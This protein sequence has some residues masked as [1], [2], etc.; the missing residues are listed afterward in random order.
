MNNLIK[1]LET[2]SDL[3]GHHKNI[4]AKKLE[5]VNFELEQLKASLNTEEEELSTLYQ[6]IR[7]TRENSGQISSEQYILESELITEMQKSI[8]NI[9]ERIEAIKLERSNLKTEVLAEMNK[10]KLYSNLATDKKNNIRQNVE[11]REDN[12]LQEQW[13]ANR[14]NND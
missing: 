4:A 8:K 10:E 1:S 12:Q 3:K 2:L 6:K 11:K 5:A 7:E 13:L 14:Y 9:L